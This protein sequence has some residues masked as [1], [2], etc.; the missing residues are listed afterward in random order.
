MIGMKSG[1]LSVLIAVGMASLV[2]Q[3][4]SDTRAARFVDDYPLVCRG[5]ETF[6]LDPPRPCEG[7]TKVETEEPR[8]YVAFT[9]I[10]GSKPSGKGLAPGECSWL[11]REMRA[12]EPNILVQEIEGV[13]TADKYSWIKEL[14][15]RDSYWTFTVHSSHGI[16]LASG[17]ERNG[18]PVVS[19]KGFPAGRVEVKSPDLYIAEVKII[20]LPTPSVSMSQLAVRVGNKGTD[21]AGEVVLDLRRMRVCKDHPIARSY[22]QVAVPALKSGQEEWVT[23][24]DFDREWGTYITREGKDASRL[25]LT[26]NPS[27]LYP[28]CKTS[29]PVMNYVKTEKET[30][31]NTLA[32]DP[33]AP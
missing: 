32:F 18:K 33:K 5:I 10:R 20:D 29:S 1:L 25:E 24:E 30:A 3:L 7:C 13:G 22:R 4:F 11:D 31:N 6:K 9:F 17:S 16:L 8:S 28:D 19:D 14:R 26:I 27:D 15:S 2:S 21:D 23:F 12:D